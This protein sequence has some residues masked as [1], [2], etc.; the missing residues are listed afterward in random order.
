M[1]FNPTFSSDLLWRGENQERSVTEDL[2]TIE[3]NILALQSGKAN[4]DHTH[5]DY[6]PLN[7][8][9]SGYASVAD[10]SALE[11]QLGTKVT[12]VSGKGLST[13]D[14]TT[15]EKNKL[16]GIAAGAQVNSITGI[17]GAAEETYRIG[18]VNLTPS[19]IGAVIANGNNE[20]AG[21]QKFTNSQYCNTLN[22]TANGVGCAFKASRV[23]MNEALVDKLVITSGTGEMPIYKYNGTSGGSMSGMTK[24]ASIG[25]DGNTVFNGTISAANLADTVVEQGTSGNFTYQKWS[26]GRAEAWYSEYIGNTSLTTSMAGGVWSNASCSERI[27]NFPSGLFI[28]SPMAIGNVYSNGYTLCQVAA[29]DTTRMIYRIWSPYSA[30]I[31]G[32]QVSIYLVGRWK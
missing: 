9:H 18:N 20:F 25:A 7:H 22:D 29:V 30:A 8:T 10:L 23:L 1:A 12:Q 15:T 21:E 24:I 14:Y 5:T 31:S 11:T 4:V 19:D 6:A 16:A 26:S 3:A 13:N 2:D 17:K 27:A 32:T 28:A